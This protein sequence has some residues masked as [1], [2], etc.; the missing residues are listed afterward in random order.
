MKILFYILFYFAYITNYFLNAHLKDD[1]VLCNYFSL[2]QI[3]SLNL[4]TRV[5]SM[6]IKGGE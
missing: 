1:F 2:T 5:D 4:E 3:S 6:N